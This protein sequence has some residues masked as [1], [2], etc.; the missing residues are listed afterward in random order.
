MEPPGKLSGFT[1]KLSVVIAMRSAVDGKMRGIAQRF[2]RRAKEQRRKQA[3]DQPAAGLAAGAV[4]H[5]DLRVAK[6]DFCRDRPGPTVP[7]VFHDATATVPRYGQRYAV[8]SG[9]SPLPFC[10][11]RSC[12]R[13]RMILPTTP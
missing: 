8:G 12:N 3:F 5:L 10:G 6:A 9:C 1:T 2:G 7:H 11:V 13:L 4:R